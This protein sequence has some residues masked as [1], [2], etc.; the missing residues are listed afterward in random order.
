MISQKWRELIF[1][2]SEYE[3]YLSVC[4]VVVTFQLASQNDQVEN[5]WNVNICVCVCGFV[6]T[7]SSFQ[8]VIWTDY[9]GLM[10]FWV[11]AAR[12]FC[13]IS[14]SRVFNYMNA[15]WTHFMMLSRVFHDNCFLEVCYLFFFFFWEARVQ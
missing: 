12:I 5:V 8:C 4:F 7:T 11:Q 10:S 15:N 3:C 2:L 9:M 14:V 13:C 1:W 6:S